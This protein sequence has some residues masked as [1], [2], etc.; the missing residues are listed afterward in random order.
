ML[1]R[2]L[3]RIALLSVAGPLLATFAVAQ[4]PQGR[5]DEVLRVNTELVQTDFMVFDKEGNFVDGLKSDQFVFKVEGK[6]RAITFFDQIAAGSRNEEAQLAAARGNPTNTGGK[7]PAAP[8]DRVRTVM[9]FLDD[10]HLSNGSLNQARAM[11][12]KFVEREMRQN[13]Q[14]AIVTASGQLGFL[15][16]LT[17]NREV[18]MLAIDR[19]KMQ[20]HLMLQT[21]ERP[22]MT[23]YN[24]LSIEEHNTDV[25]NYFVEQIL[26]ESPRLPKLVVEQ[27]VRMRASQIMEDSSQVTTRSLAAFK[28]FVE[29]TATLPGRKL[30]FFVSDGFFLSRNHSDHANRIQSI[31]GAAA[32]SGT[33][34]YSI[35]ARGLTAGLPDASEAVAFDP[36]NR[37]RGFIGASGRPGRLG[38]LVND[39]GGRAFFNINSLSSRQQR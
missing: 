26:K 39:S 4:R 3:L 10:M 7:T 38:A 12:K 21:A 8:L 1:P 29:N 6:P 23:E 32:R 22:P 15:Q 36:T 34:V 13:D 17:D 37:P 31:A 35:D 2:L 30:I 9:F 5:S 18:M 14:S 25:F 19:L 20:Q 24:A 11:L 28:S 33:V 27:M 16:Q